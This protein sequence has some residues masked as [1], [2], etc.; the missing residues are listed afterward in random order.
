[1]NLPFHRQ[2]D[3]DSTPEK[4]IRAGLT[5][6]LDVFECEIKN[7]AARAFGLQVSIV[8]ASHVKLEN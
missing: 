4:V 1:M 8:A 2:S 7:V 3:L 6:E 5:G